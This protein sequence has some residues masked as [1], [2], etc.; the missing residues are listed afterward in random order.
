[1]RAH[2]LCASR[3]ARRHKLLRLLVDPRCGA[4]RG[5][6]ACMFHKCALLCNVGAANW[7]ALLTLRQWIKRGGGTWVCSVALASQDRVD[8]LLSV[9]FL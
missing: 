8:G 5:W 4:R 9:F 7:A 6:G 2:R 1:M 3:S